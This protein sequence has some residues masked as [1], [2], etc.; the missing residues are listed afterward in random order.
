MTRQRWR[1]GV[2]VALLAVL[3]VGGAEAKVVH[4]KKST[5]VVPISASTEVPEMR[6]HFLN[7]GQGASTLI[8]FPCGVML[9]DT[10]GELDKDFDSNA[11]LQAYLDAFFARRTDLNKTIDL[12]WFTHPHIDHVR[13]AA[14]VLNNYTVKNIVDDGYKATQADAVVSVGLVR[15]FVDNHAEVHYQAVATDDFASD[16]SGLTSAVIDPFPTCKGADPKIQALWGQLRSD[17]GWGQDDYGKDRFANANNHSV[18][19]RVDLGKS[20]LLI[21]GDMELP[22]IAMLLDSRKPELLDADIYE[23]GHHGSANGTTADLLRAVTPSWAVMEVGP[24]DR[25][26]S[27]TAWAYGHPRE[28][29][30]DLLEAGV[31]GLRPK[32]SEEVG[33]GVKS[34]IPEDIEKAIYATGWDGSLVLDAKADGTITLGKVD[35]AQ[36]A[37][38]EPG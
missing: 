9:V 25:K 5:T 3:A 12:L 27:W 14:T 35:L 36:P 31:T 38:P 34:F 30:I 11:A 21:T 2:A 22:S 18:A 29:T 17:P 1:W 16:G 33:T 15:D 37:H 4:H 23:V 26:S 6:V 10:G 24:Y 8:E 20:S 19:A 13:G 32:E 7:V 28:G